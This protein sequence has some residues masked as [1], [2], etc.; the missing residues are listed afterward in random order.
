VA[1]LRSERL[2]LRPATEDDVEAIAGI[3]A[4][5]AVA[6]WWGSY[7][8][9][10]VHEDLPGS[11]AIVIDG[12]VQGWLLVSE[13]TDP[14]YRHVGL[15]ILLATAVQGQGYGPEALRAAIR[16]F[17]AQGH[18]RF[19]IDPAA[20][21]DRAIRAYRS[22]G[23]RPVGRMRQYERGP[24]GAWHDGLLMELLAAELEP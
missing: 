11:Y 20:H 17:A 16:H 8:A 12:A 4:E 14:D 15:D 3:L 22:V 6:R 19:T 18:H 2:L 9:G 21:N 24:D 5:P 7:D 1:E 10:R 13:E 23:F